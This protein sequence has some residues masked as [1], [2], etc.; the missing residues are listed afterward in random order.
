MAAPL[1]RL[2]STGRFVRLLDA[3]PELADGLSP[4]AAQRARQTAIATVISIPV[5]T[6]EP[7]AVAGP[8]LLGYLVVSGY[9]LR[10]VTLH[11]TAASEL[12]GRGDLLRADDDPEA[13]GLQVTASE[14]TAVGPVRLAL[15]D[16]RLLLALARCPQLLEPLI[17]RGTARARSLTAIAAIGHMK[18]IDDRLLALFSHLG[19][20]WGRVT[21]DG[22]VLDIPLSH[23]Q[24]GDIVGCERPSVTTSLGRLRARGI[25]R[26][27]ADRAWLL[28]SAIA[29]AASAPSATEQAKVLGE[30]SRA[31]MAQADQVR[32]GTRTLELRR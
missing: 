10:T 2:D 27:R 28:S 11:G 19:S 21:P 20:L 13:E 29:K 14:W 23:G 26:K 1:E 30:E 8:G 9:L 18:R 5:G 24:I 32:R 16:K 25:V 17:A 22:I 31:L 4:G 12:L 7:D 3:V 6:W 15:L